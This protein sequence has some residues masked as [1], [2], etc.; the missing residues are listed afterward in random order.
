MRKI[1]ALALIALLLE[2]TAMAAGKTANELRLETLKTELEAAIHE[3]LDHHNADPK[4]FV[5]TKS[6]EEI[7]ANVTR[8]RN[9]L[10]PLASGNQTLNPL[11]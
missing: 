1:L 4:P 9:A 3:Y 11:H 8:A 10:E 7:L 2:G 5:W 6:A